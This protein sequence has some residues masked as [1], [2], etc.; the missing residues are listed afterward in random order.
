MSTE[1]KI[2]HLT[3][4][5]AAE[6]TAIRCAL[7]TTEQASCR[8]WATFCDSK[9]ALQSLQSAPCSGPHEQLMAA[10]RLLYDRAAQAGHDIALQWLPSHCG[11]VGNESADAAARLAQ[12]KKN[13]D[14]TH[15][16]IQNG[17]R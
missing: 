6:L 12:K 14:H 9:P 7:H 2:A 1:F 3:T 16:I 5:T 4:S 13:G 15:S 8:R 10:I 17:R 11:I